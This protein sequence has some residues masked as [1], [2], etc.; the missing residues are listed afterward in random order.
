METTTVTVTQEGEAQKTRRSRSYRGKKKS[1]ENT[2]GS[3]T[4]EQTGEDVKAIEKN[5]R[6]NRI[7]T[8]QNQTSRNAPEVSTE[9]REP[10]EPIQPVDGL[11]EIRVSNSKPRSVYGRVVRLYLAGFDPAGRKLDTEAVTKVKLTALGGAIGQ[12]IY[13]CDELVKGKV[14]SSA[15]VETEFAEVDGRKAPKITMHLERSASWTASEDAVLQKD[16]V[17]RKSQGI[18]DSPTDEPKMSS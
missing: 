5:S 8:R 15:S 6:K 10:R 9:P 11:L 3:N 13:V 18:V 7:N 16:K 12:A 2:T 4:V 14:C 17:Y 1:A